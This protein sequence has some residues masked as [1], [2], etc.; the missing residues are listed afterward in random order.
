LIAFWIEPPGLTMMIAA[1]SGRQTTAVRKVRP[2]QER[3]TRP[4]AF[5]TIRV[6]F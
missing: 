3:A 6:S 1:C 2:R 5:S 4:L